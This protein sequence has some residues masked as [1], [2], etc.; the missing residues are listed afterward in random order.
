LTLFFKYSRSTIIKKESR[1][2]L[3]TTKEIKPD[4]PGK[5]NKTSPALPRSN[6]HRSNTTDSTYKK[7][8]ARRPCLRPERERMLQ[9]I[10]AGYSR[11]TAGLDWTGWLV[12]KTSKKAKLGLVSCRLI[13]LVVI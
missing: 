3:K 2:D 11:Q 1:I 8:R 6:G 5:R 12:T 13:V 9:H 7:Q 4:M 10:P